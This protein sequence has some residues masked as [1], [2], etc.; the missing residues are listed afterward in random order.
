MSQSLHL[1]F[2]EIAAVETEL[3]RIDG[4]TGTLIVR[5][6]DSEER[7]ANATHEESVSL[8]LNDQLPTSR[9]LTGFRGEVAAPRKSSN[10]LRLARSIIISHTAG[11]P[12]IA[13]CRLT[14]P[15]Q[16]LVT[17]GY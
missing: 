13:G 9:E 8:L 11:V 1:G 4:E 2:E 14:G 15:S 16:H 3:N 7:G 12:A 17:H 5:G 6:A 10:H